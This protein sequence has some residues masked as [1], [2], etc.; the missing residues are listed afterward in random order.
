MDLFSAYRILLIGIF[1][2]AAATSLILLFVRAPYGRYTRAGW[3]PR[4]SARFA[5]II[6]E[7]PAVFLILILYLTGTKKT[8][9]LTLFILLWQV[10]YIYRTFVYPLLMRGRRKGFPVILILMAMIF[11]CAN[12]YVNGYH[13][14]FSERTYPV[15]WLLDPRFLIGVSLFIWGLYVHLR[16]DHILRTLRAPGETGYKIPYGSMYRYVSSPN[17][18]GE[19]VQ[20]CGWAVATWSLAGLSFAV[21]TAA[22]LI[23]RAISHHKWYENNF[24]KYPKE[25]RAVVPFL[26]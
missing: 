24:P 26:L 3:G 7:S 1:I 17:Y 12:G 20:W 10:H 11:N 21:F 4:I 19:I 16:S 6:M 8:A 2:A 13:L 5:W 23:P 14:F 9:P 18:F 22:N 25:R 15:S